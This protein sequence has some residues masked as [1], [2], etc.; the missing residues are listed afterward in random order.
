MDKII[1]KWGH[2]PILYMKMKV[3]MKKKSPDYKP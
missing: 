2:H 1:V 3:N